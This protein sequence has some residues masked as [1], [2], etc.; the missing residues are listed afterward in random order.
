MCIRDR[1]KN[2][3]GEVS[4]LKKQQDMYNQQI[5][6]LEAQRTT[7][8]EDTARISKEGEDGQAEARKLSEDA[9]EHHSAELADLVAEKVKTQAMIADYKRGGQDKAREQARKDEEAKLDHQI[10]VGTLKNELHNYEEQK[11]GVEAQIKNIEDDAAAAKA[12]VDEQAK[13]KQDK[14]DAKQAK[15]EEEC[16]GQRDRSKAQADRIQTLREFPDMINTYKNTEDEIVKLEYDVS[17]AD[18]T[19]AELRREHYLGTSNH[20]EKLYFLEKE[21]E[22]ARSQNYRT[23]NRIAYSLRDP[24]GY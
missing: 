16:Q 1:Y 21:L 20:K 15:H 8:V 4:L 9:N 22:R 10:K 6:E 3:E 5:Q 11:R 2:H 18:Q 14:I 17:E 7:V 13:E 23:S 12:V 19:V 24:M